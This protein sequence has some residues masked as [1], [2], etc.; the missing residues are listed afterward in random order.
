MRKPEGAPVPLVFPGGQSAGVGEFH[1]TGEFPSDYPKFFARYT[2]GVPIIQPGSA[3]AGGQGVRAQVGGGEGHVE[4]TLSPLLMR[5]A[6]DPKGNPWGIT[7]D[8]MSEKQFGGG[9]MVDLTLMDFQALYGRQGLAEAQQRYGTD[10][11]PDKPTPPGTSE[12]VEEL[13]KKLVTAEAARKLAEQTAA[14]EKKER[15]VLEA[16]I[17]KVLD[18]MAN[19]GEKPH[20]EPVPKKGKGVY[21]QTLREHQAALKLLVGVLL[22]AI[23]PLLTGCSSNL[24]PG[25]QQGEW[26]GIKSGQPA[27]L[28]ASLDPRLEALGALL[29]L[30]GEADPLGVLLPVTKIGETTPRWVVCSAG[31]MAEKCRAI[32]LN[33]KVHVTGEPSGPMGIF[34]RASRLTAD[35]F[36]D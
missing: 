27:S 8:D 7:L 21:A 10:A 11:E 18:R 34:Y 6:E 30:T 35:N 14:A 25:R 31:K 29:A 2:G 20:V 9:R 36:N 15:E 16:G 32:P 22:L 19:G 3:E 23:V 13:R 26:D 33:A 12:E 24:I 1:E 4:T 17:R 28:T 5:A